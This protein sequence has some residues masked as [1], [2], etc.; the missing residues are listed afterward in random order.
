MRLDNWL[1]R[2]RFCKTRAHA[3]KIMSGPGFRLNGRIVSKAH[4]RVDIDDIIIMYLGPNL[5]EI[6][7]SFLPD[8]RGSPSEARTWYHCIDL[9]TEADKNT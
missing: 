1:I 6:T 4:T 3:W 8:R 5:F 2:A 9:H 7:I